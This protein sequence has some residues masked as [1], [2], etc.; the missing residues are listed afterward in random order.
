MSKIDYVIRK[1][2]MPGM[3]TAESE[4]EPLETEFLIDDNYPYI[5]DAMFKE[6][7]FLKNLSCHVFNEIV[8]EN[9]VVGFAAY[10]IRNNLALILKECYILPEFRGKRLFFDEICKMHYSSPRF[11]IL[12]P[13]RNVIELLLRYAFAKNISDDIVVSAIDLYLESFDIRS[14][15]TEELLNILVPPSNFYDSSICSTIFVHDDE[16]LYHE[17]LENDCLRG[18]RRKKL[19]KG[20]F[21]NIL[22]LF[23][24]NHE[25]FENS[26]TEIKMELPDN[27]LGYEVIVG[28]GDGLSEY[29]QGMVEQDIISYERAMFVR[30]QLINE[31]ENGVINDSNIDDRFNILCAGEF[32]IIRDFN[33]FK[34]FV[35]SGE[36]D[37]YWQIDAF[38]DFINIIGDNEELGNEF[39]DALAKGDSDEINSIIMNQIE[40]DTDF[41]RDFI[42][43]ITD[44]FDPE[45]YD[46]S[47]YKFLSEVLENKYR[48][49]DDISLENYPSNY[50]TELYLILDSLNYGENYYEALGYAEV[51]SLASP[52]VLTNMLL[53][54]DLI[55]M[56]GIIEIDWINDDVSIFQNLDLKRILVSNHLD[57]E[58]TRQELL[59]RLADN[60]VNL[61]EGYKIT[62]KGKSYLKEYYWIGFYWEFLDEFDF[63]D[64]YKY[65]DVHKGDLK[66]VSL[67]YI[68]EH[69]E[70]ARKSGDE[71]YLDE[72]L[73]VREAIEEEFEAFI[74]ELNNP[75]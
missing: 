27:K 60:N 4:E 58:G 56:D 8:Y 28:H 7:Y 69:L 37:D 14:N 68:D 53:K 21:T 3:F 64:F 48:L 44:D 24:K 63:N 51:E 50:E 73:L 20:Y 72:C 31:Y 11:G 34:D 55:K 1:D 12:Q 75:E 13:T 10:E 18:H 23:S 41:S 40:M 59:K 71:D 9:K 74:D 57:Y 22:K 30:E 26:I 5:A 61:G 36:T 2:G 43:S 19:D 35:N 46:E 52:D 67:K 38:R 39:L 6:K 32:Q 70:L 66:E 62:P 65:L 16:I 54:S 49:D 42:D 25:E 33:E 47:H 17:L 29:M 45:T 15:K